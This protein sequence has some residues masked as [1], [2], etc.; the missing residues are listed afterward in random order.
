MSKAEKTNESNLLSNDQSKKSINMR[1][2]KQD[3]IVKPNEV[4]ENKDQNIGESNMATSIDSNQKKVEDLDGDK[5]KNKELYKYLSKILSLFNSSSRDKALMYLFKNKDKI[6]GLPKLLWYTPGV[7]TLFVQ[8]II[9]MYVLISEKTLEKEDII[10]CYNI[11]SLFQLLVHDQE[12]KYLVVKGKKLF[13]ILKFN[14]YI[15]NFS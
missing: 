1:S 13:L 11:I 5:L 10:N 15:S 3:S 2:Y 12:I 4:K 8:E 9:K 14:F 7:I 6:N